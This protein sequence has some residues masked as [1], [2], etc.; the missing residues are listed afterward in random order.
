MSSRTCLCAAVLLAALGSVHAT[1]PDPTLYQGVQPNGITA[2]PKL[3]DIPEVDALAAKYPANWDTAHIMPGDT[4]ATQMYQSIL[5]NKTC[6]S[7]RARFALTRQMP[8]HWPSR[9]RACRTNTRRSSLA[10]RIRTL[11]CV[12]QRLG[13][14]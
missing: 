4:E 1:I 7:D 3:P 2:C 11:T 14:G 10:T 9:R 5:N 12:G 8:P 6:A 13:D